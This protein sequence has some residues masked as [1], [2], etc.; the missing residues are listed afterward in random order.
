MGE[1]RQEAMITVQLWWMLFV[2]AVGGA[3]SWMLSALLW[4]QLQL[5]WTA[6]CL[7]MASCAGARLE[8][9]AV[10]A[11]KINPQPEGDASL[12]INIPSSH[13]SEGQ[14]WGVLYAV[15][16]SPLETEP[17]VSTAIL[18]SIMYLYWLFL[19]PSLTFPIPSLLLPKIIS[20]INSLHPSLC[21]RLCF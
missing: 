7:L 8:E 20:Q 14:F 9:R 17:Q 16:Q 6:P 11:L 18:N 19:L 21:F 15:P 1:T 4:L 3:P 5:W 2:A 12:W 10:T 13:P